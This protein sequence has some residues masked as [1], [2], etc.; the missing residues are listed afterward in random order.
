M[1]TALVAT[2]YTLREK[3]E[4]KQQTEVCAGVSRLQLVVFLSTMLLLFLL[5]FKISD[6]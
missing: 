2:T 1:L 4:S 5:I 3:R 6:F